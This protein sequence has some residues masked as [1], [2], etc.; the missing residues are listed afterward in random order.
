MA[1]KVILVSS[2]LTVFL[3]A[4]GLLVA[5]LAR[6]ARINHAP[7]PKRFTDLNRS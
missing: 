4:L 7:A 5:G 3:P 1:T 2:F 6:A